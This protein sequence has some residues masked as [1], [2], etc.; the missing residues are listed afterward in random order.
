MAHDIQP[1]E[2]PPIGLPKSS[3][4]CTVSIVDTTCDI[5]T[6]WNYLLEPQIPG[7]DWL[8]LP[9]YSFH[10]KHNKTGAQ[11]LF[12]MGTRKDWQNSVPHI[13]ELLSNHVPGLRVKK[14]VTEILTDGGVKLDDLKALILSHWH[15]DHCEFN[16]CL[17]F[18]C[19][20][21]LF[22]RVSNIPI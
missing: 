1:K 20:M 21:T 3:E 16:D 15:F 2:A 18:E 9:D 14:D 17:Y 12:D 7:H 8:N 11:L 6:P 4:T 10:I 22:L 19:R 5:V 13:V